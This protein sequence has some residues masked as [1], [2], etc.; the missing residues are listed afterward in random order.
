MLKGSGL[1][2]LEDLRRSGHI[3]RSMVTGEILVLPLVVDG[4]IV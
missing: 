3:G 2:S 4:V 1:L